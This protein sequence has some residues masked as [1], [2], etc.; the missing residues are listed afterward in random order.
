[1]MLQTLIKK[2]NK[3]EKEVASLKK[4]TST[5]GT[6]HV[7]DSIIKQASKA[8]FDFDIESFVSKNDL[9]KKWKSS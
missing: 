8:L 1:M 5:L 4:P 6:I 7:N 2:V 3:L 9:K